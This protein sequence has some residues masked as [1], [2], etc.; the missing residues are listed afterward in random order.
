MGE[1]WGCAVGRVELPLVLDLAVCLVIFL[2]RLVKEIIMRQSYY[3]YFFTRAH[4]HA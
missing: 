1:K 3:W 2:V 4:L